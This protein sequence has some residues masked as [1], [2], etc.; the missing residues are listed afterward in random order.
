MPNKIKGRTGQR[1]GKLVTLC[2]IRKK[3]R[4]GYGPRVFWVCKCDCGK[5]VIVLGTTLHRNRQ[6]S[7]G[8]SRYR[9][10]VRERTLFAQYKQKAHARKIK[11]SLPFDEFLLLIKKPCYFTGRPPS[12]VFNPR[13]RCSAKEPLSYS[14]IDRLN[15]SKGYVSGN[16]VP[17]CAAANRAKLVLSEIEF[18]NLCKDVVLT[19]SERNKLCQQ[20]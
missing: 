18:V 17:C 9:P 4:S 2:F 19:A 1:F 6:R 11:W 13:G 10:Y 8:C 16:C 15:N 3:V 12:N 20:Q 14:G 7:C 5:E